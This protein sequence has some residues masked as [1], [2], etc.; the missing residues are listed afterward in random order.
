ML[1]HN[2]E[3]GS[4]EWFACRL[5]KLTA[6]VARTIATQG[7][8]LE[9]LCLEKATEILTGKPNESYKNEAMENGNLL[10]SEARAIYE[11]ETGANVAQVGFVEENEYIGVSPDGLVGDD[12]LIE[13]KCPTNKTYTQYLLDNKIKP[14]YYSQMQMQ[15]MITGRLWCDY[16]V[17]NPNFKKSIVIQR[18]Y[19]DDAEIKKI[20]D[21]LAKGVGIIKDIIGKI[22]DAN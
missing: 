1:I 4:E 17:Y 8:G 6:S 14:E 13:I 9:T 7:K 19:P 10:E 20:A 2:V 11:L 12:G 5:G 3:Q 22:E 18:V 15:M 16:V 21:G